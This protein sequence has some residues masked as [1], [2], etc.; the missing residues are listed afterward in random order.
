M[1]DA[2]RVEFLSHTAELELFR[3]W[4]STGDPDALGK[5]M[6][7]MLPLLKRIARP[8]RSTETEIDEL[9]SAGYLGLVEAA[10]RFDPERGFRF[11][12]YAL[13]WAKGAMQLAATRKMNTLPFEEE[14]AIDLS[15]DGEQNAIDASDR[16][17]WKEFLG[18]AMSLLTDREKTVLSC[19]FLEDEEV[20]FADLKPKLGVS[21]ERARQIEA[22]ALMRLKK[23]LGRRGISKDMVFEN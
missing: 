1:S 7:S 8:Y 6:A 15:A 20:A 9:I 18:E 5:V 23:A 19:R 12:T 17:R 16:L 21:R 13:V 22:M 4:K 3:R 2:K 14:Q 11:S 10:H